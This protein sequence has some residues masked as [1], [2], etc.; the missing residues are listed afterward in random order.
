M[1]RFFLSFFFF[2]P[3]DDKR[4]KRESRK[5]LTAQ[6]SSSFRPAN[7]IDFRMKYFLLV[8][9]VAFFYP[10]VLGDPVKIEINNCGPGFESN[11]KSFFFGNCLPS[12]ESFLDLACTIDEVKVDS[13][14]VD[15]TTKAC[16]LKRG[17]NYTMMVNFTPDF[18]GDDVTM[19]AYA[20]LPGVDAEFQG[21]D[22]NACH[23]MNCPVVKDI[24]QAYTF[25]LSMQKSYPR[26]SFSVRW[27]MKKSGQPACCFTNRF[28][29]E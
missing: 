7:I 1:L 18:E 16:R 3:L 27:L 28:K 20:L 10:F 23:W 5:L 14:L 12:F 26:G 15:R 4:C 8:A 24:P 6:F 21:M 9:F 2:V 22:D 11:R 17:S 25:N 13:C 19:L 29:I